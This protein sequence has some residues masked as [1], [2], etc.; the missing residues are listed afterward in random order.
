M[1]E[2]LAFVFDNYWS[3]DSCPEL[4]HLQRKL[5]AVGFDAEQIYCALLWLE[6]LRSA[7]HG[8]APIKS[9]HSPQPKHGAV[10]VALYPD[11]Q[12]QSNSTMRFFTLQEQMHLGHA[13]WGYLTF[14]TSIGVLAG[15]RLELVMDR[16]MAAP[17][18]PLSVEDLKLIV[19]M[20]FW[21]LGE[22]P[23]ALI[24][25]ELCDSRTQRIAH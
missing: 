19:L 13:S 25:D 5:N 12:R 14:L 1:F 22:E 10:A 8:L 20:L 11:L 6:E 21:S 24:L 7:A 17:G 3:G 16:V 18:A 15:E 9:T 2:V 23:S 4:P